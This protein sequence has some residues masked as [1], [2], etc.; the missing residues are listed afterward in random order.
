MNYPVLGVTRDDPGKFVLG[1]VPVE[2]DGSA[3]FQV[4]SG[5]PLFFQALDAEGKAVQTM[6]SA[7][8]A[9]PGGRVTCVGC[10][11]SR[12]T[13]P[14]DHFP[15]AAHR[16]PSK[17]RPGPEGSWPLDYQQLV[18]PVLQTHCVRCHR[19]GTEGA[20]WDLTAD[21]SYETLVGYGKP[22][23]RDHVLARYGEGRS[24]AGACPSQTS[25]LVALLEQNHYDVTLPPSDWQRL[26]TWLDT[27]GQRQG[28]FGDDQERRLRELKRD[29]A[30]LLVVAGGE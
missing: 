14:P 15:S 2:P 22:S 11:E 20:K 16:K 1:T 24:A 19:S 17:I 6:R 30:A 10:H 12:S 27:Y 9:Q 18:Q 21:A 3:N 29:L 13:A 26:F 28:S 25:P 4:P 8:Y 5:V 7:T 23:L